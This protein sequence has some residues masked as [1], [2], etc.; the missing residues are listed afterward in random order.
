LVGLTTP[1]QPLSPRLNATNPAS[2]IREKSE[3]LLA[4]KAALSIYQSPQND[5][6]NHAEKFPPI[7]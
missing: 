7:C 3:R 1:A 2:A 6:R 4:V 5:Q